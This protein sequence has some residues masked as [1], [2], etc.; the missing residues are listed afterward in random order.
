RA[1]VTASA[2]IVWTTPADGVVDDLPYWRAYTGQS[3]AEVGGWGWLD[4]IHPEDRER[5]AR[6]WADAVAAKR[7][8]ETE[9][10]IRRHDGVYRT[11]LVRGV[12]VLTPDGAIREWVGFCTDITERRR[13]EERLRESAASFDSLF[14]A[15]SEGMVLND[16]GVLVRVNR[17]FAAMLGYEVAELVGRSPLDFAAPESRAL[18]RRHMLD[19]FEQPYEAHFVRRD[20]T[21]IPLEIAG[22]AIRYQGRRVRLVTIRDIRARGQADEALRHSEERFRALVQ[23]ASDLIIIRDRDGTLR[24]ISPAAE[25]LLGYRPEELIGRN[26]AEL[27]HPDDLAA[28]AGHIARLTREP[29]E[30]RPLEYRLRHRD[31]SWRWV[32]G[33]ATNLLDEPSVRGIVVNCRDITERK[34]AGEDRAR[35][36]ARA[37]A[38]AEAAQA[39]AEA[40]LDL[41]RVLDTVARQLGA[42]PGDVCIIRLL[43][44]DRRW[45]V[46]A[47][48]HHPDPAAL[49]FLRAMLAE[50]PQRSDEG[51]NGRVVQ[52]GQPLLIP[53]VDRQ[54]YRRLIKPEHRAYAE[55]FGGPRSVLLVPMLLRRQVIGLLSLTREQPG[56]PYTAEDQQF[57]ERLADSAALAIDNAR[58]YREAGEAIRLR[59]QFLS[60]ASH[61]LRTPVTT[62]K[63]YAELL[64]RRQAR[65]PLT[66]DQLT[67]GLGAIDDATER[68]TGLTAD[69]LDVSRL[70]T[71]QLPFRPRPLD[72]ARLAVEVADRYRTQLGERHRLTVAAPAA[73]CPVVADADRLEQVLTNLLENAVKYSPEGGEIRVTVGP[74][75]D[76]AVLGV[77]D[78]GIG[79][80]PDSLE[81]IFQ[82]FGRA[83]NGAARQIPGLGLGLYICRDI[84]ERH[85]GRLWAESPGEGRGATLRLWLPAAGPD[86]R[87]A[88]PAG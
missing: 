45:L 4:A 70:R 80:P 81:T 76:G 11:F 74:D 65:A 53:V 21:R 23:H 19:G 2:Q 39:F 37:R 48:I 84:V 28:M 42:V 50:A 12:P 27:V 73:P 85:G 7:L 36:L 68:L 79:L 9:Y 62:I 41:P 72:L 34:R 58:L 17:T 30:P 63:A 38:L 56:R 10:R 59:D 44:E 54:E 18:V 20:G 3:V 87:T 69:L 52:T 13:S 71:G 47:A 60:I 67:R 86:T 16:G 64:L 25:R 78:E 83:A 88:R 26:R 31:G 46:P 33:T 40:Q 49:A 29:V 24:Y 75:G 1:L 61:E 35:L 43:S 32:E 77:R 51:L 82:P 66:P 6:V 8:Y 14:E 5:T 55:R 57:L 22:K 15:A